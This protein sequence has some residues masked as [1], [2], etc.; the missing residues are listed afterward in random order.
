VCNFDYFVY[1]LDIVYSSIFVSFV[2]VMTFLSLPIIRLQDIKDKNL[3]DR[4]TFSD[5]FIPILQGIE[6]NS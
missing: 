1:T 4:M 5:V 2:A 3:K 6:G